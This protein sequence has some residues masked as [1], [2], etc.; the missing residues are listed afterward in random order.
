MSARCVDLDRVF[1]LA[2]ITDGV[3]ISKRGEVTVGWE[4][5]LPTAFSLVEEDYDDML[6]DFASAVRVLPQWTMVHRQDAYLYDSCGAE[7]TGRF[8]A[9]AYSAHF[10][11]RRYLVHRQY[12]YLT[13]TSKASGLRPGSSGGLF[14]FRFSAKAPS[15]DELHEFLSKCEDF[16]SIITSGGRI[17]ARRLTQDELR[18]DEQCP[19][20]VQRY[21]ML[22]DGTP[23]MSDIRLAPD[24][25]R[26]GDRH[27]MAF[28]ICEGEYMPASV[29][30]TQRVDRLSGVTSEVFLSYSSPIGMQLDCEHVVNQYILV[31]SQSY[32]LQEL[33]KKRKKE[34]SGSGTEERA[35]NLSEAENRANA[36]EIEEFINAVNKDS[37]MAVYSHMNVL[38]WGDED[39]LP[40]IK[41]RISSALSSMGTMAVQDLY[42]TPVLYYSGIPGAACEIGRDNLMVMELKSAL[43]MGTGETFERGMPGGNFR[44]CDRLRNV[45]VTI[46]LQT[47]A[48]DLGHIDNYN[49]FVLGPS[50]SGKSFFMNYYLRQ[51]Y[52]AGEHI[53]IIDVGDSYEGLCEI[54]N[55]ESAGADGFYHSWDVEHPFSFNPFVGYGE[56]LDEGGNLRQDCNGAT[57]IMSFL[58]TVWEPD[59][60]WRSES[61]PILRQMVTD[62]VKAYGEAHPDALP[63]FDDFFRYLGE[64]VLPRIVPEYDDRGGIVS[65]PRNP[66]VVAYNPVTLEHFDIVSYLR[67]LEPYSMGGS[68]SFLLND[69]HPKDLFRSRFTVFEVDRLSQ[70][71]DR[72]FY[73]L[74]VL[75]IM[76]AFDDKM[77]NSP[78]FKIMVIEEAWKA[79]ANETMAPYLRGLWK[80]SRKFQTS[81][82][83]VTQQLSDLTSSEIISDAILKNSDV[84]ILLDQSSNENDFDR[85]QSMMALSDKERNVVMT[86]NRANNPDLGYYREVFIK[87]LDWSMVGAVE[88]SE[89]EA[90]AYQSDK[91]RKRPVYVLARKLQSIREAIARTVEEKRNRQKS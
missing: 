17:S 30:S 7:R 19:G 85:I 40:E 37:L 80:T 13:M 46:D 22:G 61:T 66:Y 10:E 60:G 68:Y 88:S 72:K 26:V 6:L 50:G 70:V 3:V 67:A 14:G 91:V 25:V 87:M 38:A 45:P 76:N 75:C 4:L 74:C 86:L 49:A 48:R 9:D 54:I 29:S 20:M 41:G 5:T 78:T 64:E 55:E 51:M 89:E 44:I 53:F 69:R 90:L 63:V 34:G 62:F 81:A 43:C 71:D 15:R 32:L 58:Q 59:G 84:K 28:A 31:P 35:G 24:T 27:M 77:R 18:G 8:L 47:V 1:P 23:V 33:D 36:S 52:D 11:G 42:D 2:K 79:I 12:L 82:M 65:L 21:M 16:V 73:S 39:G 56:W 83:V 57:F